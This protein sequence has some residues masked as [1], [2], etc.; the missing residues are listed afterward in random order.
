MTTSNAKNVFPLA[1]KGDFDDCQ[2]YVKK[3]FIENNNEEVKFV[4]INSINWTRIMAQ[5]VIFFP[6]TS[7]KKII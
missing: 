5:S 6:Q 7:T 4:S 1:V 2:N 3:M